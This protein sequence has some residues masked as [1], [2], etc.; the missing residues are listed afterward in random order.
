MQHTD[1]A[2]GRW[3]LLSLEEQLANIGSEIIRALKWKEN[4]NSVI[5]QSANLR[6]L[7][8]FDLTLTDRCHEKSVKEIARLRELWMDFYYGENRYRQTAEQWRKY[9][10]AFTFAARKNA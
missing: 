3:H 10:S 6:A 2:D 5:S 9:F 1:L 8:L 4:G 7:E